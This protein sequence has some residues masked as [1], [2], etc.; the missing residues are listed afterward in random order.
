MG[1]VAAVRASVTGLWRRIFSSPLLTLNGWIAFD[2]PRTVTALGASL[3]IGI[4]AAHVYV[5]TTQSAPPLYFI[6]YCIALII[7]CPVIAGSMG[8]VL[9]PVVT[10]VG[11]Y[12]GSA[13]CIVFLGIYLASRLISLPGLI[14]VSGRWDF[15]PGTLAMAF[16][17]GFIAVHTTVLSGINVA[18]P[19][20]QG[21]QD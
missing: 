4:A 5:L 7:G 8:F 1:Y 20:R 16:A 12:A 3:L 10:Q 11:W 21:W 17:A 13:L 19:R 14:A 6:V 15:A 2:L 9:K 18:Y